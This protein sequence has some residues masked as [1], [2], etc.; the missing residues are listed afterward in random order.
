MKSK[1]KTSKTTARK[2]SKVAAAKARK[3]VFT[4][5]RPAL[6]AIKDTAKL[7]WVGGEN[8]RRKG[9]GPHEIYEVM[10]KSTTVAAF[11]GHEGCGKRWIAGAVARGLVKLG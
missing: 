4:A 5:A 10:R 9:S 1:S 7:R 11:T 6:D 8:P 2:T 3:S